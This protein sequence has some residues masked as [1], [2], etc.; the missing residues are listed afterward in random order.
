MKIGIIG[1]THGSQPALQKIISI[2]RDIEL[3]VHTGDH[4][5]DGVY[6]EK[7]TGIP[8][9]TVKGNC[10]HGER[11]TELCFTLKGKRFFL[12]HGHHYGVKYGLQTMA[13]RAEE[14]RADYCIFGHTH[15]P[16]IEN[17]QQIIFLNPGSIAWPRNESNFAGIIMEYRDNL[18][19]SQFKNID[20]D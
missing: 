11:D 20:T 7:T 15:Q 6:L 4:W 9:Y 16:M 18:F 12:T 3:L 13:Y 5:Q 8:V 1:D 19:I 17:F 2:F 10:D 14:L